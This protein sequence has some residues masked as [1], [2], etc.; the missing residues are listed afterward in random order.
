M[1]E[2]NS[3]P[4]IL[5]SNSSWYLFHYRKHLIE[6][7]KRSKHHAL[8]IAPFDLTSKKLSSLLIHIPWKM[9]RAKEQNIIS[10]LVSFLRLILLIRAIKPKLV[11]SHTLQANLITSIICSFFGINCVLSFAGIGRFSRAKGISRV[12]FKLIFK[13]IYLFSRYQR[14][15]RF[16]YKLQNNRSA[17]IFQ[18]QIDI[19]F[20]QNNICPIKE[21]NYYLIPGSGVPKVYISNSK[22]FKSNSKWF[23][24][25]QLKELE[26]FKDEITFIF[27]A[28]L[29]KTK[30]ILIFLDLAKEYP[31]NKFLIYGAIDESSRQS[32]TKKEIIYF[33][34][35]YNNVKFMN[36]QKN[37]LLN[38]ELK[39]P[40]LCVPSI[41]GEG[42]PRGIVEANTL[43]I[44]VI[45][46]QD[47][48]KKIAFKN[49]SYVSKENSLKSY[50]ECINKIT[51]DFKNNVLGKRLEE[52]RITAISKFSEEKIV[53][54]TLKI[55][56]SLNL[57]I[58]NSYLLNKDKIKMVNWLPQ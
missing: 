36:I 47:S 50:I 33:K 24:R 48:A 31:K 45:S 28:R 7:I 3:R 58:N 53:N 57:D 51:D 35:N 49:S 22:K 12:F 11:H 10:F 6:E 30:G 14:E 38:I 13:T 56:E 37:P 34:K 43:S 17:F 18:N 54:E 16:S 42:F 15:T 46:S 1:K 25:K 8:A 41:Y 29:L 19:D 21:K 52:A 23:K 2:V 4:I 27:C 5:I 26:N 44:P 20:I 40:I 32:L 55:Y 9:S 39:L